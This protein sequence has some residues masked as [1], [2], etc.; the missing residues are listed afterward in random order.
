MV[1]ECRAVCGTRIVLTALFAN[2]IIS[3][4]LGAKWEMAGPILRLLTPASHWKAVSIGFWDLRTPK[5][6]DARWLG[7]C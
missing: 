6:R 7:C 1:Q 4:L 2:E 3:I 5:K